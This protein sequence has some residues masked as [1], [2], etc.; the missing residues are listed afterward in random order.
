[1]SRRAFTIIEVIVVIGITALLAGLS[2]PISGSFLSRNE[3]SSES[4]KITDSLRRARTQSMYGAQDSVW[5]V[6]FTS[7]DYTIFRGSSYNPADSYNNTTSLPG[8]LSISAITINGGGS[9]IIFDRVSGTTSTFGTTTISN[10]AS[11]IRT[12]VVNS[13]GTIN[14]Q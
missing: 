10:D 6:H 8:V 5:G 12:I 4:V 7:S 3:L 11:E 1:M 14:L 9:D 13:A 2:L